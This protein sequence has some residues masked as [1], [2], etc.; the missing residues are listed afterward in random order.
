M[1]EFIVCTECNGKGWRLKPFVSYPAE[2]RCP[3]C[4]GT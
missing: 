3:W 1:T 2:E 4:G